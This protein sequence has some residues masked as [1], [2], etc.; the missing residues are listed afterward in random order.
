MQSEIT[1][2]PIARPAPALRPSASEVRA[3]LRT[4]LRAPSG[5]NI[6]PWRIVIES[7]AVHLDLDEAKT[8]QGGYGGF[9]GLLSLGAL[10]E[11][12]R[13]EAAERGY[14]TTLVWD[15]SRDVASVRV[16]FGDDAPSVSRL[17]M[18]LRQ[19]RTTRG[20]FRT[21]PIFADEMRE[22]EQESSGAARV[23]LRRSVRA[24]AAFATASELAERVR[25][26]D[27]DPNDLHRWLRFSAAE[28]ARTRDGLDTRL[29]ALRSH[30]RTALRLT[31][32]ALVLWWMRRFGL[33]FLSGRRLRAEVL[34]S[35]AVGAIVMH[36]R[37]PAAFVEAG[38]VMLRTWVRATAL[39][40][41][42]APVTVAAVLPLSRAYGATFRRASHRRLD[43]ADALVRGTFGIATGEATPF[44][45]RVGIADAPGIDSE[46]RLLSSFVESEP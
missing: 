10:A 4:A 35:G 26:D 45:F 3:I 2:V 30:E 32:S 34:S 29:L 14:G 12:V 36:D 1:L 46:R 44:L 19:R 41:A 11:S 40:L 8:H 39:G 22:L 33:G 37:S 7:D 20:P 25:F 15:E 6:Q 21:T 18:H 5:D 27:T 13:I 9:S 23:T 38:R 28:V 31:G 24:I 43:R 42:F 17:A 16:V